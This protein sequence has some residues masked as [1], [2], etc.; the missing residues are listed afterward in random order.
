VRKLAKPMAKEWLEGQHVNV[1]PLSVDTMRS[2]IYYIVVN[3]VITISRVSQETLQL[4][5]YFKCNYQIT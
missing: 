3:G 5:V 4:Q 2:V 1:Y